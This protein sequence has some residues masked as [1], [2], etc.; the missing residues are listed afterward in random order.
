MFQL[1]YDVNCKHELTYLSKH[2][3]EPK[4]Q[5]N[6]KLWTQVYNSRV[7]TPQRRSSLQKY[8]IWERFYFSIFCFEFCYFIRPFNLFFYQFTVTVSYLLTL[9]T[10]TTHSFH[11]QHNLLISPAFLTWRWLSLSRTYSHIILSVCLYVGCSAQR[12]GFKIVEFE[13]LVRVRV[14]SKFSLLVQITF[15]RVT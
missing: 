14:S 3:K 12:G 11:A 8:L 15:R 9:L 4:I 13:F 7:S 1:H 10:M 5:F 2:R 6:E